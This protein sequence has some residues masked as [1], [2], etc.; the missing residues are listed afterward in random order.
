MIWLQK[1]KLSSKSIYYA[2]FKWAQRDI[3]RW[4][5]VQYIISVPVPDKILANFPRRPTR[6]S[7]G[8]TNLEYF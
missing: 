5:M 2:L 7:T 3:H 6:W 4:Y 1:M 8:Y